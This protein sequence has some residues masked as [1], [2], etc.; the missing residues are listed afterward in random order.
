[1]KTFLPYKITVRGNDVPYSILKYI[2]NLFQHRF[3][4]DPLV[5]RIPDDDES[6]TPTLTQS[7]RTAGISI[8]DELLNTPRKSIADLVEATEVQSK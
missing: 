4:Y 2:S 1:M 6:L 5:N 3:I 8:A 7:T